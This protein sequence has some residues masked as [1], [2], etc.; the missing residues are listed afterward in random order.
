[1]RP[2]LEAERPLRDLEFE[3]DQEKRLRGFQLL[4]AKPLLTAINV[5]ESE[6]GS[7]DPASYAATG[8]P[9]IVVSAPIEAEIAHLDGD[10]APTITAFE[11]D[12]SELARGRARLTVRHLAA[13]PA[14]DVKL[15]KWFWTVVRPR[16][17][18]YL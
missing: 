15:R 6:L 2:A 10:G 13:A 5:D 16:L 8:A 1:M 17:A 11:N 7:V 4:S 12:L 9:A 14:V 18:R 3:A